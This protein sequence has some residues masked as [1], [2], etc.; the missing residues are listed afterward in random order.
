MVT[1]MP[2]SEAF[3]PRWKERLFSENVKGMDWIPRS[4]AWRGPQWA[5]LKYPSLLSLRGNGNPRDSSVREK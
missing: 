3:T 5:V 1:K 2:C 4:I